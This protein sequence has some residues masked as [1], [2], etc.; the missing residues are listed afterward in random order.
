MCLVKTNKTA[1]FTRDSE[2]A[3]KIEYPHQMKVCT[4]VMKMSYCLVTAR[5]I[6]GSFTVSSSGLPNEEVT[7]NNLFLF[8]TAQLYFLKYFTFEWFDFW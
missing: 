3:L 7:I 5:K 8:N 6:C 1:F 4:R 2:H